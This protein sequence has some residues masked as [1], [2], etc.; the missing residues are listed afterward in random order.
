MAPWLTALMAIHCFVVIMHV[1]SSCLCMAFVQYVIATC[2]CVFIPLSGVC[3]GDKQS[4]KE[5]G[6]GVVKEKRPGHC[7]CCAVRFEDLHMVRPPAM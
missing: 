5:A 2:T 1:Q 7:E 6:G 3:R 4:G